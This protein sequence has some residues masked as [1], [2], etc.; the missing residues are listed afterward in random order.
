VRRSTRLPLESLAP[1]LL[2]APPAA[3]G[4]S[5]GPWDWRDVFGNDRPVEIEV[6]CGKGLFLLTSAVSRPEVNFVGI[7]VVRKYQLFTATRMAKRGLHNVRVCC[8]DARGVLRDRVAAGSVRALHVYFPDP[9][10]KTQHHKRRVFTAEFAAAIVRTLQP[11]GLLSVA[12]DVEAYFGVMRELIE[13]RPE[14]RPLAFAGPGEQAND[15]DSLTNFE[16]KARLVGKPVYRLQAE[17][18]S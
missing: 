10:W 14:L 17:R 3:A 18:V 8:A 1:Y 13:A 5:P 16:R 11:G 7:E 9:W 15:V 4:E 12:T 6:G 2:E